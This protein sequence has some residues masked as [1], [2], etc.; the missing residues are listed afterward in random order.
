MSTLSMLKFRASIFAAV[1]T[2]APFTP[3]S[4]AQDGGTVAQVN[5][6]F[7]FNTASQHFAPGLYRIHM[8]DDHTLLI[9]GASDSHLAIVRTEDNAQAAKTG[10]AVFHKYG[11]QYFLSAIEVPGT[12][13]KIYL[14][15]SKREREEQIAQN[16]KAPAGVEL[17][18]LQNAR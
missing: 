15:P 9:Q 1:L 13:R 14:T 2:L 4:L 12:S 18:L 6:P 7:A 8:Q 11:N 3:A 10:K 17:S 5:V 16:K